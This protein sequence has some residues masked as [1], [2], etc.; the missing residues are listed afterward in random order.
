M[1]AYLCTPVQKT[2][3]LVTAEDLWK[4]GNNSTHSR[5]TREW[6]KR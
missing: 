5:F 4:L 1:D 3:R 2:G 6:N